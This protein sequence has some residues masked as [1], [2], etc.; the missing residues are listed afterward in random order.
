MTL[1]LKNEIRKSKTNKR[2][3]LELKKYLLTLTSNELINH[4]GENYSDRCLQASLGIKYLLACLGIKSHLVTGAACIPTASKL[5]HDIGWQGFWDQDHHHWLVND[6]GELVDLTIHQVNLH[7]RSA[8]TQR[9]DPP[10]IWWNNCSNVPAIIKYLPQTTYNFRQTFTLEEPQENEKMIAFLESIKSENSRF[11][12]KYSDSKFEKV[13]CSVSN[14]A[15]WETE[16][17]SWTKGMRYYNDNFVPLPHW[18][19]MRE[20]EL[21]QSST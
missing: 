6:L 7:P 4:Y 15:E 20:Q 12:K 3:T 1:N 17:D 18:I 5:H 2:T 9:Y 16:E 14:L 19:I 13:L 11:L 8:N 10:P 21:L